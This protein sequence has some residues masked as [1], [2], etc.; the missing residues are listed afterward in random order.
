VPS[1]I[2]VPMTGLYPT[3]GESIVQRT[4]CRK[5]LESFRSAGL[6]FAPRG[7]TPAYRIGLGIGEAAAQE[8]RDAPVAYQCRKGFSKHPGRRPR[9]AG[10]HDGAACASLGDQRERL[11]GHARSQQDQPVA[12]VRGREAEH[13]Q[14]RFVEL[15]WRAGSEQ[16]RASGLGSQMVKA[17]SNSKCGGKSGQSGAEVGAGKG[18]GEAMLPEEPFAERGNRYR[19]G[20]GVNLRAKEKTGPYPR[21]R[22]TQTGRVVARVAIAGVDRPDQRVS[23]A[24]SSRPRIMNAIQACQL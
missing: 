8:H 24:S 7:M 20:W 11:Q 12:R 15:A 22:K 9:R 17:C 14:T 3:V 5:W 16:L 10:D 23:G 6:I 18:S 21:F 19:A 1:R 2:L 4:C 13:Q